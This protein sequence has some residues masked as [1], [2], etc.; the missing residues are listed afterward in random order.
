[1]STAASPDRPSADL[2]ELAK[3]VVPAGATPTGW[4]HKSIHRHIIEKAPDVVEATRAA[5]SESFADAPHVIVELHAAD[6][7]AGGD[8]PLAQAVERTDGGL[9]LVGIG[10]AEAVESQ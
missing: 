9:V 1:M 2:A 7:A 4:C 5:I 8:S 3:R 10:Y 6:F